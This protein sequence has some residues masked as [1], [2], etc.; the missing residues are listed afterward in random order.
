MTIHDNASH[1]LPAWPKKWNIRFKKLHA[2]HT[3]IVKGRFENNTMTDLKITLESRPQDV[4]ITTKRN[5]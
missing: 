2:T 1:L 4:V 5:P 3:T